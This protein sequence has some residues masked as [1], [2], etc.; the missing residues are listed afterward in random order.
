MNDP[1]P[2]LTYPAA[3]PIFRLPTPLKRS[4]FLNAAIQQAFNAF[5]PSHHSSAVFLALPL[6]PRSLSPATHVD[7]ISA[8]FQLPS[9]TQFVNTSLSLLHSRT[10]T[11]QT[12]SL[13]VFGR[14]PFTCL[15]PPR[16]TPVDVPRPSLN[17]RRPR[18]TSPNPTTDA[19][20]S[21]DVDGAIDGELE[22]PLAVVVIATA[23]SCD[24][25]RIDSSTDL[26][27]GAS[28]TVALDLSTAR[29]GCTLQDVLAGRVS[30]YLRARPIISILRLP[31]RSI[32]T[33][34]SLHAARFQTTNNE[35]L[36]RCPYSDP[37]RHGEF[38]EQSAHHIVHT[39]LQPR[40][41]A[42]FDLA[43]RRRHGN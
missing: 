2:L 30:L 9:D 18:R 4:L 32:V 23:G 12:P 27:T 39:H 17:A 3:P 34:Q 22:G 33:R 7:L 8:Y 10:S 35:Y 40:S 42:P 13:S 5:F 1:F 21:R 19:G 31:P 24:D 41:P 6:C 20:E 28:R 37:Q 43:A 29:A 15:L 16:P 14:G 11:L 38:H 25:E 36:L 26:S